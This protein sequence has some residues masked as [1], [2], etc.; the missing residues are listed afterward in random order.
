MSVFRDLA[1]KICNDTAD[2]VDH[3]RFNAFCDNVNDQYKD[4]VTTFVTGL[5]KLKEESGE[6]MQYIG[7][8]MVF[9]CSRDLGKGNRPDSLIC[10]GTEE[11]ILSNIRLLNASLKEQKEKANEQRRN[12]NG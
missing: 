6:V 10:F 7:I 9:A 11:A 8:S 5:A 2:E 1:E 4:L 12:S 3:E